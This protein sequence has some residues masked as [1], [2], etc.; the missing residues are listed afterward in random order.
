MAAR[1]LRVVTVAT[2]VLFALAVLLTAR[3]DLLNRQLL[4]AARRGDCRSIERLLQWAGAD[5]NA[6]DSFG[7]TALM[8]AISDRH[9]EAAMLLLARGADVHARNG[10]DVTPLHSAVNAGDALVVRTLVARGADV[11]AR[12]FENSTP[13]ENARERK[14]TEIERILLR[15]GAR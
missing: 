11:N 9:M 8:L 14:E 13:L 4:D 2:G 6:R 7:D 5:V 10:K 3:H 15:A 1:I 12:D